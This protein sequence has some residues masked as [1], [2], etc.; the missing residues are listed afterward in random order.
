MIITIVVTVCFSTL[1]VR[2]NNDTRAQPRIFFD[3]DVDA[4]AA[5]DAGADVDAV[6][7]ALITMKTEMA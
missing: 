3:A 2:D 4:E 7:D 1:D 6:A 5:A